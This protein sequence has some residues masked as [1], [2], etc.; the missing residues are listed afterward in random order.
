MISGSLIVGVSFVYLGLLFGIAYWADG[1]AQQGRSVIA[2]PTVYALSLAVYCTAWTFYGSV[3]RAA[4]DGLGFL[5]I[6]LGPTLIALLWS[7][8][9]LK[10]VRIS[11]SERITSIADFI[12]SRY[13]KSH[14]LSGVVTVIAV[15]GVLPYIA[16][17]L[18]AIAWSFSILNAYP[19]LRMPDQQSVP[20]WHDTA[21]VVA[22]LLAAFTILFGTRHL[23]ASE[24]HEGMVAAIAFDSIVKLVAFMAVGLFVILGFLG[25]G[26]GPPLPSLADNPHLASLLKPLFEPG[27]ASLQ[28]WIAI[29]VLAG[30]AM[31]VLPRQFQVAVVEISDE[32]HLRR[33]IWLFP[34]YLLLINLCV[35]PIAMAG[36]ITFQDGQVD[37]DTFVLTLPIAFSQPWLALL[38]FIGGLSA[39]TGMVIVETIALSTMVSNDLILPALTR[40]WRRRPPMASLSGLLI[41][42][43]RGA[44]VVILLLGY[45]YYRLA[46]EAY[47]LIGIGLISFV[48]VAQF[49]PALI[50]GLYWRGGTREG[51]LAGLLAGFLVWIY[52]LLLPSFARSG[53]LPPA[54]MESGPD[55]LDFLAPLALFGL[56]GW[57][58]ITHGLF[59]SLTANIGAFLLVSSLRAPDAIEIARA[60]VFVDALR[61]HRPTGALLWRGSAEVVELIELAER[62]LGVSRARAAFARYARARGVALP[63][64]IPADAE[65]VHF[66]ETLLSG[67]I[68]SASARV[69]VASVTEEESLGLDEVL[70]ILNE[71]SQIRAY[72]HQLEQKSIALEAATNELR[73]ANARLQELDQLKDDFVSSV[74]H[75]LRT[76]LASIRAFSEILFDDPRLQ[77][78]QRRHFLGILVSETERLSR[79]VNQVLDLAKLESGHADW[80]SEAVELQEVIEQAFAATGHLIEERG[81]AVV[82]ELHPQPAVVWGDRDRLI[83]VLVN[84]LSNGVKY[85]PANQGRLRVELFPVE[86]N[87]RVCIADNGPG[88]PAD[89]LDLVFEKFHQSAVDG[90]KPA[91]TGLGLHI[92]RQIIH[93]LG[94]RIWA[95]NLAPAGASVCFELP[96]HSTDPITPK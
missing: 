71:A 20:L 49:A 3:G 28:R 40:R 81:I 11:K 27:I 87:W 56:S 79:L 21:F 6:Y 13:G 32:R 17:Q 75:E 1:R 22:L 33:A 86:T 34:L 53:W 36:L 47:A 55:G 82:R 77:L 43:R 80:R 54:F 26:G 78:D 48:A 83:Q 63:V 12:G 59:W 89:E 44:I 57:D 88:I 65:T 96:A 93:N 62:I 94:G 66:A 7:S 70:D 39:A 58:E 61:Q 60:R 9:L 91:G 4:E 95:E 23:D 14:V 84:L 73:A 2:H 85:A 16:L 76:P 38:V 50:G 51:A 37:A 8:L 18:K 52:T 35:I 25:I 30:L 92:C 10:M 19:D 69:M 24:R 74:T 5:P 41:N 67:A 68:G 72:S 29:S 64:N 15:I 90:A 42:I 46:G 45:L 31:M